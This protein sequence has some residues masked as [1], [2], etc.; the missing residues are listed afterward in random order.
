MLAII[1]IL[2]VAWIVV[3]LIDLTL[4]E[5]ARTMVKIIM[6]VLALL[7]VLY[8]IILAKPGVL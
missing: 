5:S 7:Y 2:L 4:N 8:L 6:Y 3:P 1:V